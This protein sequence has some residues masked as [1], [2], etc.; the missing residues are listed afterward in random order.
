MGPSKIVNGRRW[1]VG[2]AHGG[3]SGF[4]TAQRPARG[5]AV[6][7]DHGMSRISQPLT[8]ALA[9][10]PSIASAQAPGEPV[11]GPEVAPEAAPLEAEVAPSEAPMIPPARTA[12][13][14]VAPPAPKPYDMQKRFGV[15]AR[16]V[17]LGLTDG[18][19]E[20]EYAGGGIAA[21]YRINK[22]WELVL[23]LDAL[24][25]PEGPDLHSTSL[26]ARFH[27]T[28]HRR[29]DWYAIVG[30]GALHETD[31]EDDEAED[32]P[33]RARMHAGIGLQRR[34]RYWSLGAEL[35]TVG[36]GPREDA[37]EATARST[38]TPMATDEG[39]SGG[40]LTVAATLFF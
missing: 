18:T 10:I 39:L 24:D 31:L 26:E 32:G 13:V 2:I 5:T 28:P 7:E 23:A 27:I 12:V 8:I 17:S 15:S 38:T 29:W 21:S 6:D 11:Y 3:L 30:V 37:M 25:A 40:E 33:S 34:F 9:L 1:P 14:V 16:M 19:N 35:H 20:S 36:V 22:R 4:E